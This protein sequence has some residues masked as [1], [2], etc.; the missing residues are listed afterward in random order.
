VVVGGG[1]FGI[2]AAW[3]AA[4]RGLSVAILERGDWAEAA[5]ANCFRM[6]HGGIRY[7]QHLDF[8]RIHQSNRERNILLRIAPHLVRPLPILIPTYGHGRSGPEILGAGLRAY[9][10]LVWDRNRGIR[11]PALRLPPSRILSSRETLELYPELGREG[12]TGGALIH[13]GQMHSP[14]RLALCALRSAVEHGACAANYVEVTGFVRRQ[15]AIEGVVV[16]DRELGNS[17]DVRGRVVLNAAGAWAG[18]LLASG[19]GL[20]VSP[21]PTF[22]RD[23]YFVLK[24]RIGPDV[25]LAV[26]G[27]TRD[28][29]AVLSRDARHLFLVPWGGQTLVGVWHVVYEGPPDRVELPERDVQ[30][31]IDEINWAYPAARI[32]LDSVCM[33]Q[34]GLV[35]FGENEPGAT[36]MSYGKR[37]LLIDHQRVD[38][39]SGLVTLIGVRYT[40]ARAEAVRAVEVAARSL[41]RRVPPSRSA[42]MPIHGGALSDRARFLEEA[43]RSR[44]SH[45]DSATIRRLV[46]N[47]GS[48]YGEILSE[49]DGGPE[50]L[51]PISGLDLTP[52]EVRHAVRREMARTLGDLIFR[53]TDI[54]SG[55][56]P[57]LTALQSCALAMGR[58]LG[59]DPARAE[60]E[61]QAARAQF[62]F[63]GSRG[64]A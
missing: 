30:A 42:S 41:K 52:A 50:G 31:F 20:T 11:D 47:H 34:H 24:R 9:D 21:R 43:I 44:P 3:E 28:P 63:H 14:A 55:P 39:L 48:T 49:G 33:T 26:R 40:T 16:E 35:L 45:V 10:L 62:P 53:R 46:Q 22:S 18:P 23:A 2:F 17:F 29:D 36:N 25:A 12:L 59:W 61:A 4:L 60:R 7:L 38:G 58:E 32:S 64:V 1:A 6:V 8:T 27:R 19:L 13:D 37:S 56:D 15:D 54:G 5:S 57:G 51:Q